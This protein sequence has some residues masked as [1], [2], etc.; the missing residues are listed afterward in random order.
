MRVHNVVRTA[1][2]LALFAVATRCGDARDP[3][4]PDDRLAAPDH[5][6][7]G[8]AKQGRCD[9]LPPED[10]PPPDT[11][12]PPPEEPPEEPPPPSGDVLPAFPGAEGWGATALNACRSLPL[13]VHQVT[14]TNN[15]GTGTL[16]DILESQVSSSTY[17]VVVFRTGG[18]INNAGSIITKAACIYIAG[19]TAPG[20]GFA[21]NGMLRVNNET[22]VH[23]VVIRYL[24]LRGGNQGLM[25]Q[26][27]GG[28]RRIV[29]DH[30]STSWGTGSGANIIAYRQ[31][32]IDT[33]PANREISITRN[34]TAENA[35]S[36]GRGMAVGGNPTTEGGRHM[37]EV[38][39][40]WNLFHSNNQ[41]NPE[42]D[43]GSPQD[44]E[45]RGMEVIN[46]LMHNW[47]SGMLSMEEH[48]V[49]D[50][51]NNYARH[52]PWGSGWGFF[53]R[54]M[55]PGV[56]H[57]LP[58]PESDWGPPVS[59]YVAGNIIEGRNFSSDWN[60]IRQLHNTGAELPAEYQRFSRMTQPPFP[61]AVLP[62]SAVEAD[63]LADVGANRLLNADGTWRG[64][65][66]AADARFISEVQ[67]HQGMTSIMSSVPPMPPLA[68]GT[69]PSD[70]DGDGLPDAW[71]TRFFGS[72]TGAQP[73]AV[74]ASGYLVIE[75]YLNGTNPGA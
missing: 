67:N 57:G 31:G 37:L 44:S 71:E 16:R 74:T 36:G 24:R 6:P 20:D 27:Q 72:A 9:P 26:G 45:T 59:V 30:N 38:T 51:V 1:L 35:S 3:I 12:P 55:C 29:F 21:I 33:R 32:G 18:T 65:L 60:M 48:V 19:Q 70:V 73:G 40:A 39:V 62:A 11:E 43:S 54:R 75:H 5:C 28:A 64:A 46:N 8:W 50:I 14:N 22:I 69:P 17:D 25:L 10:P 56:G 13:R 34:I 23:D 42:Y 52:G 68:P 49:T 66:D 61:V 15:F 47:A 41:R 63:V 53:R 7:P 58:C 2:I 4:V